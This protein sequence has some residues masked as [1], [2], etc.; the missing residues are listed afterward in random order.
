MIIVVAWIEK[1]GLRDTGEMCNQTAADKAG[2]M[3][4]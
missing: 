2:N 3:I 4:A 1:T